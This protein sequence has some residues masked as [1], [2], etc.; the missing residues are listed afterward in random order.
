MKKLVYLHGLN[1]SNRSQKA[2]ILRQR[3]APVPVVTP[4]YP[5]HRPDD[6]IAVLSEVFDG[7]AE[8]KQPLVVGSSMGGF[9]GQYLARRY[10]MA[11]L[12]MINPALRPWD[13]MAEY[14]GQR[15]TTAE[16]AEY[17]IDRALIESTRKYGISE[18]CAG[19]STTLFLDRGDEVIDY[20]IAESI[21]ADCARVMVFEGGDHAFQHLDQ[22]IEVIREFL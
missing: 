5:A 19:I 10:P 12:F 17:K 22:A 1:S 15:M 21:Y 4:S 8:Q 7:F 11:H 3:L 16:G 2:E 13:L 14:L 20:R 18:P 6:A 9:Y